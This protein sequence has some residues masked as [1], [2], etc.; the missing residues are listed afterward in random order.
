MKHKAFTLTE[1]L[2]VIA[3]IAILLAM[4][5]PALSEARIKA[6]VLNEKNNLTNLGMAIE[7]FRND[8]GYYP[9]SGL[10]QSSMYPIPTTLTVGGWTAGA[11]PADQGAHR[12]YESLMGLDGLG[13]QENSFYRVNDD[14]EP[15][16][17]NASGHVVLTKRSSL[18]MDADSVRSGPMEMASQ[19]VRWVGTNMNPVFLD[20]INHS[21]PH[22]I[23]Y[24]RANRSKR[25]L[26]GALGSM[27]YNW[28]DNEFITNDPPVAS[29]TEQQFLESI[30]DTKTGI[31]TGTNPPAY[32]M[33]E[34]SARPYNAD[35]FI[36]ICAGR[37]GIYG[38]EDDIT[39]FTRQD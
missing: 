24:Y 12:L 6:R 31:V 30:W 38:T 11:D 3:I 8:H 5:L 19:S 14:G 16:A 1:L 9:E 10:R 36:L 25:L 22:P 27:I 28:T 20:S 2:V 37:D 39:N 4:A 29:F 33:F 7:N 18:Y 32:D 21:E 17:P 34:P 13:F 26:A 35:S 15:V 23:L